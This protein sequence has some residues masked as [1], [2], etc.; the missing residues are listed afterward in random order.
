MIH[1]DAQNTALIWNR[2]GFALGH[3]EGE[4]GGDAHE[5]RVGNYDVFQGRTE[6]TKALK[7]TRQNHFVRTLLPFS[8]KF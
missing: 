7:R 6:L 3:R 4:N 5:V 2:V 8:S 1:A